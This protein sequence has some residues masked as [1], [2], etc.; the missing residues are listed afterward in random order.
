MELLVGLAEGGGLEVCVL[1]I[2]GAAGEGD[3]AL[4]VADG[5]GALL[6]DEVV[7]TSMFVEE[8]EDAG[9]AEIAEFEFVRLVVGEGLTDAVAEH[10]LSR[11]C[12]PEWEGF[13][14]GPVGIRT[15]DRS[16]MSRLL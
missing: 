5:V 16:V 9:G 4:V 12:V 15:R 8:E 11:R 10:G 1:G 2:S 13:G 6:E 7:L 3:F 14:G